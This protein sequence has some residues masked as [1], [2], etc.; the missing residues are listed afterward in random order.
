MLEVKPDYES[1]LQMETMFDRTISLIGKDNLEKL[2]NMKVIVFGLGGVGGALCESLGR[3]GIGSIT[4]VDCDVVSI[5]NKNRQIIALDSTIGKKKTDVMRDRLLDINSNIKIET[6][7]KKIT[8]ENI[9][10]IALR[11]YDYVADAVDDV[12]AKISIIEESKNFNVPIISCMGTGNKL[13]PTKL[14]VAD[15]NDTNNCPLAKKMRLELRKRAINNVRVVFTTEKHVREN[16]GTD[17]RVPSSISYVPP[18]AGMIMA[19]EIIKSIIE[20]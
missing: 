1:R 3:A 12:P 4:L 7:D 17:Q 14:T 15:I 5:S 16:N 6:I 10:D 13:D 11:E 2:R 18:V 9:G 8:P 19:S 20:I